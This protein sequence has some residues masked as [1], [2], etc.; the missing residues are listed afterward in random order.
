ILGMRRH[1]VSARLDEIVEFSGVAKYIDTPVKRYSSG[2][3]IRLAFAVAAHLD[4]EILVVDEVLAVGDAEFQRKCIGKM[5]EVA[6]QG[7]RTVLFVSHNMGMVQALCKRGVVLERGQ[8]VFDGT[9][10]QA[11]ARYDAETRKLAV[12]S[13]ESRE[14]RAGHGSIRFSDVEITS[15]DGAQ[16]ACGR[17]ARFRAHFTVKSAT[18]ESARF[19]AVVKSTGQSLVVLATDFEANEWPVVSGRGYIDFELDRLPVKRGEYSLSLRVDTRAG[20]QDD[21]D[22]ATYFEVTEGN[23]Y[24]SGR[25]GYRFDNTVLVDHR[26]NV[27]LDS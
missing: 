20:T 16:L 14:D 8:V 1:E 10:D 7:A 3:L 6:D 5:R 19:S 21:I 23:F 2:M 22:G 25:H 11:I 4:C 15:T 9:Q 26:W 13:L 18:P 17:P 12:T 27:V 24:G